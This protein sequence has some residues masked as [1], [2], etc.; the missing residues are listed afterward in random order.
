MPIWAGKNAPRQHSLA[1]WFAGSPLVFGGFAFLW[2]Q[3]DAR[4]SGCFPIGR[5]TCCT[6]AIATTA[7]EHSICSWGIRLQ[8]FVALPEFLDLILVLGSPF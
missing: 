8:R 3:S 6:C 1:K 2:S 4:S 5:P 7:H